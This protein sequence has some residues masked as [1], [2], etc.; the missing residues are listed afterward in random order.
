MDGTLYLDYRL[1]PGAREFIHLLIE[2]NKKF[3]FLSNNSSK[4]KNQYFDKLRAFGLP[5]QKEQILTSGE[6]TAIYLKKNFLGQKVFAQ[7][8]PSLIEELFDADIPLS[9]TNPDLVVLGYDTGMTY[10][11]LS[12][13]CHFLFEDKKYI[14]T[15]PDINCPSSEGLIPDIGSMIAFIET[16]TCRR[17]DVIIGKP[18]LPILSALES[19][20]G[21][22]RQNMAM[23][24][25]RLYTDMALGQ[26]G[27]KTILVLTG[28]TQEDDLEGSVYHPDLVVSDLNELI[29]SLK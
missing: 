28:E 26:Y 1:L 11:S 2:K 24:G 13:F 23:L 20:F 5:V 12:K 9:E 25:D 22:A 29:Q 27:I 14:A 3:C 10:E 18:Y 16:V 6:A 15:H 17:P 7:G 4:N 8:T 19:K 21:I